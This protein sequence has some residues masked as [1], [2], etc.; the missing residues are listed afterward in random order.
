MLKFQR[1][2]LWVFRGNFFNL[3]QNIVPHSTRKRRHTNLSKAL[4]DSYQTIPRKV[5]EKLIHDS[6]SQ[7]IEKKTDKGKMQSDL[8]GRVCCFQ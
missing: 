3:G 2:Q 1:L 6:S 5:T 4:S 7:G 8:S